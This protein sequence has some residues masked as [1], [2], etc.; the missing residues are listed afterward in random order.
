MRVDYSDGAEYSDAGLA[1]GKAL[2]ARF[3]SDLY[4]ELDAEARGKLFGGL[5]EK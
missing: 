3:V 4:D 1:K 5:S 2:I